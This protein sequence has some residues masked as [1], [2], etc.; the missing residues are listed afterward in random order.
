[1]LYAHAQ[2]FCHCVAQFQYCLKCLKHSANF[3]YSQQYTGFG[4]NAQFKF[5]GKS[6]FFFQNENAP[7]KQGEKQNFGAMREIYEVH[8]C[9]LMHSNKAHFVLPC[10]VIM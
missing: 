5:S 10:D 1:M 7:K 4:Y 3:L 8:P 6:L 2:S 9:K